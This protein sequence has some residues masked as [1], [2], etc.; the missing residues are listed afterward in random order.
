MEN[1][2]IQAG[3]GLSVEK[4][5][6]A[7]ARHAAREAMEQAGVQRADWAI[8]Y[9]TSDHLPG[10]DQLR[11]AVLKETGCLSLCGCSAMGVIAAG[12][13]VEGKPGVGVMVGRSPGILTHSALLPENGKGLARFARKNGDGDGSGDGGEDR[14]GIGGGI[15]GGAGTTAANAERNIVIALP[16][17]YRVDNLRLERIV[18]RELP[19]TPLYGAGATDDGSM[20]IALQ[21]GMEGVRSASI[22]T[23]GFQGNYQAVTGITQSCTAV[24]E[25]HFI[26][27]AKD[28]L[29]TELDS[30]PALQ[31]FLEQGKLLG[32]EDMQQVA[33]QLL[34]GFP[35]DRERPAFVGESCLV[36]PLAGFDQKT[37]GLV[38]PYPMDNKMT[39]GFMHRSPANAE[40]DLRRMVDELAEQL[41]GPPDFG[42]YFDCAARGERF[43]GRGGVDSS[44]IHAH[45]GEFPLLGMFGGFELATTHGAMHVYSF[46]GVLLLIRSG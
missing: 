44:V 9:F 15:G 2:G 23:L 34:F 24:G 11:E 35:L 32:L 10:A 39:M 18:G 29:L 45:L 13:E 36:R 19:G 40:M 3:V 16:D 6:A 26:T 12:K 38:I 4:D 27:G 42:L 41:D 7:A 22:S 20:G 17:S 14:G 43:Y 25:P 1:S 5:T 33:D 37:K 8:C 31:T 28:F 46:T 21:L 30:R